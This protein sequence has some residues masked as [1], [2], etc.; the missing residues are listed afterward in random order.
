MASKDLRPG[1]K[2]DLRPGAAIDRDSFEPPYH[3]LAGI[4][5]QQIAAGSLRA[6]DRLPSEAQLCERYAVSPMTVRRAI[7]ILLDQGLITTAQGR[8][9]FV[10]PLVLGTATFGLQA[11]EDLFSDDRTSVRILAAKT[12]P[13]THRISQKLDVPINTRVISIRRLLTLDQE[14]LVFHREYL[15]YDPEQPIVEAEMGITSLAGLFD[16]SGE[17]VLKRGDLAIETTVL[18]EEES[19]LLG[20]PAGRAA[21]R[22]EH[23]FYDF[24]DRPVSWGWF[25]IRGDCLRFN[26]TVGVSGPPAGGPPAG[27]PAAGRS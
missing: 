18:T 19:L 5:R 7:N 1:R 20:V 12:R 17:T 24:D 14:P 26:A 25:I 27:A 9:T 4:L 11:L 13:A 15:I 8:G 10:K 22:I 16:G 2:K 23:I 3:Q 6:G 21:F